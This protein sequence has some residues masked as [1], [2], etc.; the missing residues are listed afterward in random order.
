MGHRSGSDFNILLLEFRDTSF[1]VEHIQH[2][3]V[4]SISYFDSYSIDTLVKN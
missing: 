1:Y 2:V 4:Q 3:T